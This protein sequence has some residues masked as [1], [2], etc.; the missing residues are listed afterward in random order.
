LSRSRPANLV[1]LFWMIRVLVVA[2]WAAGAVAQM[3]GPEARARQFVDLAAKGDFTAAQAMF[4]ATLGAR[5]SAAAL[6]Q[7]W[8]QVQRGAGAFKSAG[9]ARIESSPSQ[10]VVFLTCEFEKA[11]L[12]LRLP[13]DKAGRIGGMGVSLHVE[14]TPPD[15]V[16]PGSFHEKEVMVGASATALH[17]TL[18]IPNGEGPFPAV[19]L[20]HGSG[21]ADR[22]Y[23]LG[24]NKVFRDLAWGLASR[25]V[26]VLRYNKRANEYPRE[27]SEMAGFTVK[28]ETVD[29]AVAAVSLLAATEGIDHRRIFVAGHSLGATV[30]PRIGKADP[31]IAGLILMAGT[32]HWLLDEL[33]RQTVYN[34]TLHG[35]MTPAQQKQVD[36]LKAQVAR[37]NDPALALDAPRSSL[38][39]NLPASYW[40]DLRGYHPEQT[41]RELNQPL[42]ILQGERDYQVTM[43]DFATWKKGLAGKQ[44]VEFKSY[45]K[46]NHLF[47]AG[48][49][50]SSD[51]EYG[52]P[53]HVEKAVVD[54]MAAWVNRH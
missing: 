14:Y 46:L 25:G 37:A 30:G 17:G 29:D 49:G 6:E 12:D 53:G 10:D 27:V 22:D 42:L 28:E 34:F 18:S 7:S 39:F 38:P 8:G 26:A 41:A 43:D 51:E 23:T 20:V 45:P 31:Q 11:R 2:L 24:P 15:Y 35:E 32:T 9:A 33:V 50:P 5:L 3:P 47:L 21:A 44:N 4:D 40:L 36:A 19:V 16:N 54:D 48:E 1:Y 13:M 52:R